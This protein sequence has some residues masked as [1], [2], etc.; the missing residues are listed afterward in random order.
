MVC[1]PEGRSEPYDRWQPWVG[2]CRTM[3]NA[4][5]VL[6]LVK[7]TPVTIYLWFSSRWPQLLKVMMFNE[8]LYLWPE[9][10]PSHQKQIYFERPL[11]FY[12]FRYDMKQILLSARISAAGRLINSIWKELYFYSQWWIPLDALTG[13]RSF[14]TV[15]WSEAVSSVQVDFLFDSSSHLYVS[16]ISSLICLRLGIAASGRSNGE[17]K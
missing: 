14:L 4:I 12:F 2:S 8:R 15:L 11:G 10:F 1:W 9:E 16:L 5:I 17:M 3:G 7:C 13:R 6:L